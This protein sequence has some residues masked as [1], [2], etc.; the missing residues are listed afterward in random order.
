MKK[1]KKTNNKNKQMKQ[2]NISTNTYYTLRKQC[3]VLGVYM[4]LQSQVVSP[5]Q[6]NTMTTFF[7][8]SL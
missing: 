7:L 1:N 8:K 5:V 3:P 4:F 2:N 6:I